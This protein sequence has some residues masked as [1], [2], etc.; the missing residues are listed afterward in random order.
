MSQPAPSRTPAST[1]YAL[2]LL[3]VIYLVNHLDRQIM[4]ILIEP[5]KEDLGLDD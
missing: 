3:V 4:Y 5:V 1:R 2:G